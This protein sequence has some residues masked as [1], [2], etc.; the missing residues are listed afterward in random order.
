MRLHDLGRGLVLIFAA[1]AAVG[2]QASALGVPDWQQPT[3]DELKMTSYAAAPD[4]PAVYLFREETEDVDVGTRYI[5]ARIKILTEK[6]KEMFSDIEIP[7]VASDVRIAE[8]GGRTILPS[9]AI[10]PFTGQPYDKL[11]IKE[12]GVRIMAKVFSMPDVEV[13]SILEF[14]Y[15]TTGGVGAPQWLIQQRIPVLKAHY[16]FRPSVYDT[17]FVYSTRLP[18]DT[19]VVREKNRSFD[20]TI[21]NVPALPREDYLPPFGNLSYRVSF[22]YSSIKTSDEYWKVTGDE[23]TKNID[24][25][26]KVSGKIRDAVN[27]IVAPADTDEQK[28]Q[29]I[30]A[31]VMKIENTSFTRERSEKENKAE[32]LKVKTAQDIWAQQRGT[33]DEIAVLFVALVRAAGLK[34]LCSDCCGPRPKSV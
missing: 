19:Q 11:L 2:T 29:K 27:G 8:L 18:K 30:Y 28:V 23:W 6:G 24:R 13:G 10:L 22:Y 21:E 33:D 9:G 32:H 7:Y 17:D 12:G 1:F 26:A 14:R 16:N 4:A 31:A 3:A 25:F 34:G 15:K 20:L 5:Y